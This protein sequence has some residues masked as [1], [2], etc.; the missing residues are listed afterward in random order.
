MPNY[1][2][3]STLFLGEITQK[4]LTGTNP[5]DSRLAA[6]QQRSQPQ[7]M[8]TGE[9]IR[10]ARALLAGVLPSWH[11]ERAFRTTPSAVAKRLMAC[12]GYRPARLNEFAMLSR[13]L[14]SNSRKTPA[15]VAST[16]GGGKPRKCGISRSIRAAAELILPS[17][18]LSRR[19]SRKA[20]GDC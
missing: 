3:M 1:G 5:A 8:P 9:Q 19:K 10:A 17:L 16:C 20:D 13:P 11:A 4:M 14:A 12:R 6:R 15:V 2:R 7:T 18:A